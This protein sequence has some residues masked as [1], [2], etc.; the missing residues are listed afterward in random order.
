MTK[1]KA[2]EDFKKNYLKKIERKLECEREIVALK[3]DI[4]KAMKILIDLKQGLLE[5]NLEKRNLD[6]Y[7]KSFNELLKAKAEL[8]ELGN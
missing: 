5:L 1:E 3:G 2:I 4:A 6:G 7:L 8:A